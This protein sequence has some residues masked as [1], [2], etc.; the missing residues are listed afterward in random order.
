MNINRNQREELPID[1]AQF[2]AECDEPNSYHLGLKVL[3]T[4]ISVPGFV[5]VL[6]LL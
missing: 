6:Y 4:A 2:V 5:F 3:I 1:L